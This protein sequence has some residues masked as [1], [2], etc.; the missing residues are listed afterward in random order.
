L[1]G[2]SNDSFQLLIGSP[3]LVIVIEAVNPPL[4]SFHWLAENATSHAPAACACAGV[5]AVGRAAS[6]TTAAGPAISASNRRHRV[7]PLMTGP[8]HCA[9]R[10]GSRLTSPPPVA[11]ALDIGHG[12]AEAGVTRRVLR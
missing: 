7:V 1:P 11:D 3:K 8:P 10:R 6:D 9:R 12:L 2:S 5:V 4:P